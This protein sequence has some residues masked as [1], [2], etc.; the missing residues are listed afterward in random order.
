MK[1][2]GAETVRYGDLNND[3]KVTAVDALLLLNKV[4]S[5]AEYSDD[6]KKICD[7]NRDSNVNAADV[8]AALRLAA[9]NRVYR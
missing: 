9:Q 3:S 5:G 1:T 4:V 2:G 7:V 8:E 6:E